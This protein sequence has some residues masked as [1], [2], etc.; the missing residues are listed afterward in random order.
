L[1]PPVFN[2]PTF[3]IQVKVKTTPTVTAFLNVRSLPRANSYD[4]GNVYPGEVWQCVGAST[5]QL[6]N[7][8]FALMKD[9]VIGWVAA[10]YNGQTW[11][12]VAE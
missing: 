2:I 8:W 3:P 11:L 12:E 6:G 4:L 7:I 5:D 1:P 9:K 10:Y